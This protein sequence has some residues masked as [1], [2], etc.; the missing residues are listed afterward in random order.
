MSMSS[1]DPA[2]IPAPPPGTV[3]VAEIAPALNFLMIGATMGSALVAML[4]ALFFFSSASMRRKPVFILN[5]LGLCLGVAGAITNVYEEFRTLLYPNIPLNPRVIIA[6]GA[7]DGVTPTVIDSILLLRL[8]VVYPYSRTP[9]LKFLFI[10]GIPVI[11]KIARIINAAIFLSNYAHT[12]HASTGIGGAAVLITSR[13]PS[14]KIEWTLQ[15]FDDVFSSTIFLARVYSQSSF[16][17][18]RTISQTVKSLFWISTSNFVFPVILGIAQLAIYVARPDDYLIALYVE[19]VNFHF[20]IMGVVFATLWVAESR[21]ADSQN[22]RFDN[23]TCLPLLARPSGPNT[24]F[25]GSGLQVPPSPRSDFTDDERRPIGDSPQSQRSTRSVQK[26]DTWNTTPRGQRS[27]S[28][29]SV[30]GSLGKRSGTPAAEYLRWNAPESPYSPISRSFVDVAGGED[31]DL[32]FE[33]HGDSMVDPGFEGLENVRACCDGKHTVGHHHHH[34][35]VENIA[36]DIDG[37]SARP[38]SPSAWSFRSR[39]GS[40]NSRDGGPGGI[41]T[42]GRADGT[43]MRFGSRRSTKTAG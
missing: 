27:R 26:G 37:A 1:S 23:G 20:T 19:A 40:T 31:E 34:L 36:G 43:K 25:A 39:S 18:K 6:M 22:D 38:V 29:I 11:T 41:F 24:P 14:V 16:K 42:W 13:L 9:R 4:L 8:Y 15:V 12:I 7:F 30:G 5:V 32:D 10:M 2:V 17:G 28:Q 21:W 33:L 35:P 3:W